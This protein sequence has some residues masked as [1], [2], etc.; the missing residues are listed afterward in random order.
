MHVAV[1]EFQGMPRVGVANLF[2]RPDLFD[3]FWQVM[4]MG[5]TYEQMYPIQM[6]HVLMIPLHV[7]SCPDAFFRLL[8]TAY[9][10]LHMACTLVPRFKNQQQTIKTSRDVQCTNAYK[11]D[12][13]ANRRKQS[14]MHT[15]SDGTSRIAKYWQI[16]DKYNVLTKYL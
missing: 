3:C 13:N 14:Q 15:C 1:I 6:Q 8:Y 10:K 12:Q 2:Q 9:S 16:L 7:S 4:Q 11:M 5:N